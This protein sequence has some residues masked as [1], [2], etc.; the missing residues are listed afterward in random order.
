M[1]KQQLFLIRA[2][3]WITNTKAFLSV[4]RYCCPRDKYCAIIYQWRREWGNGVETY[5]LTLCPPQPLVIFSLVRNTKTAQRDMTVD[6]RRHK[7]HHH[8]HHHHRV[9][10]EFIRTFTFDEQPQLP[11]VQPGGFLVF[12]TTTVPPTGGVA[13][14]DDAQNNRVGLIVPGG[15]Y[16]VRWIV[17]PTGEASI[18]LLVNGED[19]TTTTAPQFPDCKSHLT[20][21]GVLERDFFVTAPRR[22]RN[23]ISIVNSGDSLFGLAELPGSKIGNTSVITHVSVERIDT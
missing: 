19:P 21:A 13:F 16:R 8:H 3:K 9:Y 10:G 11:I 12:P 6:S 7:R 5:R 1:Y 14:V 2:I 18:D 17:N 23:L 22:R 15:V 20:D 4:P